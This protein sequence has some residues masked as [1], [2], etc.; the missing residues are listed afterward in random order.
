MKAPSW[1]TIS[2]LDQAA[3]RLAQQVLKGSHLGS[4]TFICE[5]KC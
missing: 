3:A 1:T 5:K 4:K 2:V